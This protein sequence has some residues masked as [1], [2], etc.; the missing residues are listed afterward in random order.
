MFHLF[1]QAQR[2]HAGHTLTSTLR[3]LGA[4]GL[5]FL[6]I[7]DS[8]PLPTFGGPD[9]VVAILSASH[10]ELWYE[11]AATAVAGSVLGA[12]ITFRLARRAGSAYLDQKFKKSRLSKFLHLF[13]KWGTGTLAA[14]TAIPLPTPTSMFF[15]AAGASDYPK[16]KFLVVVT[17]CRAFRYFGI[18]L[19]AAYY[20]RNFLRVLRHPIQHWAWMLGFIL[21]TTALIV[22][23]ILISRRL[24]PI[25]AK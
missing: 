9:I 2:R 3:H 12:Y 19:L 21:L 10:H 13:R 18:A 22:G 15:A 1:L 24:S 23:G 8:A 6:A 14:S 17:A 5:F 4:A 11:Y 25:H 16:S 20:G 7:I